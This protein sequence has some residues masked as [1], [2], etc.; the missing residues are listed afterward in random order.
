MITSCINNFK[1]SSYFYTFLEEGVPSQLHWL[2]VLGQVAM[3]HLYILDV[4]LVQSF[5]SHLVLRSLQSEIGVVRKLKFT[6]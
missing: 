4:V 1:S 2:Q 6:N 5:M 3:A